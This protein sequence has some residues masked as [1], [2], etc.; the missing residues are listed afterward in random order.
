VPDPVVEGGRCGA[1]EWAACGAPFPGQAR[2]GDGFLVQETAAG[3]LAA[4]VDGLG[5][6]EEAADVAER[7]LAS[8]RKTAG[9]SLVGALTACHGEL[10][11]SRGVVMTLASIDTDWEQ[12]TW[13]A[14]GNVEAAVVRRRRTGQPVRRLSV[15]LRA[16]V[17]GDRLPPLR[18]ATVDMAPGDTLIAATDGISPAFL[19]EVD[20]SLDAHALAGTLHRCHSRKDDDTLVVVARYRVPQQASDAGVTAPPSR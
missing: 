3:V 17:V 8:V 16:G 18:E 5:H 15:P 20:L 2:S 4:V 10:R 1:V 7:A 11:G 6:G 14:V 9:Q 12:L 13:V 19:D